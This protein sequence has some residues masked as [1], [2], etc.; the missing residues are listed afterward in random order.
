MADKLEG[1]LT[2][3]EQ[4]YFDSEGETSFETEAETT[5]EAAAPAETVEKDGEAEAEA[6]EAEGKGERDEKGRFVNYGA[7]HAERTKRQQLEQE[8]GGLK[9]FKAAMEER[10][11]WFEAATQQPQQDDTPPDPNVDVFAALKWT[12]DKLLEQQKSAQET[13]EQQERQTQEQ[14]AEQQVW[15]YWQ[16]D[17]ASYTKENPDFGNA[18]KWLS[19]Y[20]DKQ[21]TAYSAVDQRFASPQARNAQIE[22]ELKDIV[23]RGAQAGRSP[24][25][26]VYEIAKGYGYTT[27][28]PE[29]VDPGKMELPEKLRNVDK[30]QQGSRTVGQASGGRSGG[31]EVSIDSLAAMPQN[32]FNEWMKVP[33]NEARFKKMM[34]G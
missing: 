19:D 28:P 26:I 24:A 3:A 4:A 29:T 22:T 18:A 12:Q 9:Q 31:D 2:E 20:R 7:L 34:G 11:R 27:K 6:A 33:A 23:I 17:A 21:L 8:V 10:M 30:A 15:S 13:R 5:A 1:G 16:Q 14:Q 32:E 25:S